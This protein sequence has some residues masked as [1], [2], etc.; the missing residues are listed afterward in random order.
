MI[1]QENLD[2]ICQY[3]DQYYALWA[4]SCP[5]GLRQEAKLPDWTIEDGGVPQPMQAGEKIKADML[6]GKCFL[7]H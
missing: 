7:Q 1:L 2:L 4:S 3:L 5:A 6:P